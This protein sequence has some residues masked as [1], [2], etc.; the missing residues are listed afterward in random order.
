MKSP[1]PP[2][3]LWKPLPF[4]RSVFPDAAFFGTVT[5]GMD[6][7]KQIEADGSPGGTP[8]VEHTIKNI[9]ITEKKK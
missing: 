9:K 1:R 5:D 7:V 8:T 2:P 3:F 6:V 4:S